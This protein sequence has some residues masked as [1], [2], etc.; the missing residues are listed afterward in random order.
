MRKHQGT[1][2][3][4]TLE[5]GLKE[6]KDAKRVEVLIVSKSVLTESKSAG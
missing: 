1:L 5:G 6:C 2:V 4:K 3:E